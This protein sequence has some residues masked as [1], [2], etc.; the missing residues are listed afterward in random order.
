M[1]YHE[2]VELGFTR[3]DVKDVVWERRYG[4][5]YFFMTMDLGRNVEMCWDPE[6]KEVEIYKTNSEG[7]IIEPKQPRKLLPEEVELIAKLFGDVK[8]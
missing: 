3:N 1:L 5:P 2:L 6:E 4:Y 7:G 8:P